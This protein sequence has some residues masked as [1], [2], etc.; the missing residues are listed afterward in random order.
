[1]EYQEG[2]EILSQ[3]TEITAQALKQ[4]QKEPAR[5]E[6]SLDAFENKQVVTDTRLALPIINLSP[7][8]D[9]VG[10]LVRDYKSRKFIIAIAPIV[11]IGI[12]ING[13]LQVPDSFVILAGTFGS[14]FIITEGVADIVSRWRQ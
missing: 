1:M 10:E 12:M 8:Y 3:S 14:L 7:L 5:E 4:P 6:M 11:G 2:G 9:W 13:G